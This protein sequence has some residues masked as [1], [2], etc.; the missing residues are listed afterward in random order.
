[1]NPH[2]VVCLFEHTSATCVL[3]SRGEEE[4]GGHGGASLLVPPSSSVRHVSLPVHYNLSE[5]PIMLIP[6]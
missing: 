2:Q 1:M 4:K 3:L 6:H 5:A